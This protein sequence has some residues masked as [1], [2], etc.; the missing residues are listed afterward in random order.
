MI[1]IADRSAGQQWQGE[2]QQFEP[3][4]VFEIAVTTDDVICQRRMDRRTKATAVIDLSRSNRSQH[5]SLRYVGDHSAITL[6]VLNIGERNGVGRNTRK[7][8]IKQPWSSADRFDSGGVTVAV[9]AAV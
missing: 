6:N 3:T 1:N 5:E 2:A 9:M 8:Y 4:T 7:I